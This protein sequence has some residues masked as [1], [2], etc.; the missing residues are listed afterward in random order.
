ME[1]VSEGASSGLS[2]WKHHLTVVIYCTG[3]TCLFV[4]STA[5]HWM[6]CVSENV[7]KNLAK[8]DYSG[9]FVLS[10]SHFSLSISHKEKHAYTHGLNRRDRRYDF[11]FLLSFHV[12]L[13]LLRDGLGIIL[14]CLYHAV[15]CGGFDRILGS[16]FQ[17]ARVQLA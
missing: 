2:E 14:W 15:D 9:G 8:L 7:Y 5:F 3:A 13:L 17:Q 10:S 4:L 11:G 12:Q 6:G 1:L 16:A